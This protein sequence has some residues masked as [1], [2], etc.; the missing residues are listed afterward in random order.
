[1][2]VTD[3]A[4][5]RGNM[6]QAA[7]STP[8]FLSLDSMG[9]GENHVLPTVIECAPQDSPTP[10]SG[11]SWVFCHIKGKVTDMGEGLILAPGFRCLLG[12]STVGL[13]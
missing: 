4:G 10:L 1:M 9:P 5:G 13:N 12:A 3:L 7:A 6:S 11:F 8:C 2:E